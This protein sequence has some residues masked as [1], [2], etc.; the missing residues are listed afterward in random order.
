MKTSII[1]SFMLYVTIGMVLA[2]ETY[3][4]ADISEFFSQVKQGWRKSLTCALK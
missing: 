4:S 1:T 3:V 2:Q